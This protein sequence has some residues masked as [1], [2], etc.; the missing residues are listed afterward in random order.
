MPKY[1]PHFR[2]RVYR[3]R[4]VVKRWGQVR[5]PMYSKRTFRKPKVRFVSRRYI[6]RA[7]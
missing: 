3:H 2:A 5:Q 1:A 6:A 7:R 4:R